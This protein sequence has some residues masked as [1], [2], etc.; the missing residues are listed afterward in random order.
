[1][2]A[3]VNSETTTAAPDTTVITTPELSL[4]DVYKEA[5][6]TGAS[7]QTPAPVAPV[8]EVKPVVP[9]EIEIPD[10][11][12]DGHKAFLQSLVAKQNA[13]E[14]NQLSVTAKELQR[15]RAAANA[16]LEEDISE[17]TS[18]LQENAGF[19]SLPYDAAGKAQLARYELET[20]ANRD[21]KFQQLWV[22][23]NNSPAHKAALQKALTVVSKNLA[24]RFEGNIDP[25]LAANRRALKAAQSSSAT[26]EAASEGA[27][28]LDGLS[29][30]AFERAWQQMLQ[31]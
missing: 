20:L 29:G 5:G 28:S 9:A 12:D 1:M 31:G 17:A 10:A 27:S 8:V 16:K 15:E 7:P 21:P 18:F 3:T 13:L 23:R 14:Q 19:D 30:A 25:K 2:N 26:T 24:K 11:Y 6:I 4:E 22:S